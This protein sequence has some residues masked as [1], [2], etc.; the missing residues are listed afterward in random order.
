MLKVITLYNEEKSQR[1]LELTKAILIKFEVP[2]D[3]FT[4]L[5]RD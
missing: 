1:F 5:T 2:A 3:L 4:V